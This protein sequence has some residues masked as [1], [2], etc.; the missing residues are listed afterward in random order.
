MSHDVTRPTSSAQDM[1]VKTCHSCAE[2]IAPPKEDIRAER[3]SH[4][5]DAWSSG[6]VTRRTATSST[7][8]FHHVSVVYRFYFGK[9]REDRKDKK[10]KKRDA[11]LQNIRF[12]SPQM[13]RVLLPSQTVWPKKRLPVGPLLCSIWSGL[14]ENLGGSGFSPSEFQFIF[15][16]T[17]L[18]MLRSLLVNTWGASILVR[19]RFGLN[20]YPRYFH[21]FK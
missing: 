6:N 7:S 17:E 10:G 18:S 11:L 16:L 4:D 19:S 1:D 21:V 5:L 3:R 9:K 15:R 8:M 13:R 14:Y 12:Q 20:F 2:A